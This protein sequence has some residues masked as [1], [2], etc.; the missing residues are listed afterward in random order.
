MNDIPLYG[1]VTFGAPLSVCRH[2]GF[3]CSLAVMTKAA[4]NIHVHVFVWREDFRSL[5]SVP[6]SGIAGSYGTS[7]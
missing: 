7:V 6:R 3:F 5:V 4:A 1:Y 2:L